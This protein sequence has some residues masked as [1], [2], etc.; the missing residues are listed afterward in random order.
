MRDFFLTLDAS[1]DTIEETSGST[2]NYDEVYTPLEDASS[3]NAIY[4]IPGDNTSH[5]YLATL[6]VGPL[7]G[8]TFDGII[9]ANKIVW[10]NKT[11]KESEKPFGIKCMVRDDYS[12]KVIKQKKISWPKKGFW[13]RTVMNCRS[14]LQINLGTLI[15]F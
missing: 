14:N 11:I 8:D 6:G 4:I 1:I 3:R 15:K 10:R 9:L 5:I 13:G 2:F 7:K 12:H